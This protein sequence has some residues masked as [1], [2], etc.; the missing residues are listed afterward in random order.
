MHFRDATQSGGWVSFVAGT[1]VTLGIPEGRLY[2]TETIGASVGM[3]HVGVNTW[4]MWG[5]LEF[6]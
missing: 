1:G 5:L 6:A 4:D 2:R 3:K